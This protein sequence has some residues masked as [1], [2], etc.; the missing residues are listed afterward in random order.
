MNRFR[1]SDAYPRDA[2]LDN[3]AYVF[4]SG[5]KVALMYGDR[6][7]ACNWYG[8]EQDSLAVPHSEHDASKAAGYTP[9]MTNASLSLIHI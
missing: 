4:D 2:S 9:L 5:V 3:M 8:G 6:D 7:F 1:E